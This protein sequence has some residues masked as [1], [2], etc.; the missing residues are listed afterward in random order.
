MPAADSV[1][2]RHL[3][4]LDDD[5]QLEAAAPR[6]LDWR[7]DWLL[8]GRRRDV[9]FVTEARWQAMPVG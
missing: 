9:R 4:D 5:R 1:L 2:W 8:C 7:V 3:D 6:E